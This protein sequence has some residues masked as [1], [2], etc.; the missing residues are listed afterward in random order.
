MSLSEFRARWLCNALWY[1]CLFWGSKQEGVS[2]TPTDTL[3]SPAFLDAFA[4][5]AAALQLFSG[6]IRVTVNDQ[7][8]S[9]AYGAEAIESE[10]SL[11]EDAIMP[12]ASNTKLFTAVAVHQLIEA[13]AIGWE[14]PISKYVRFWPADPPSLQCF[15]EAVRDGRNRCTCNCSH[16][17]RCPMKSPAPTS[18]QPCKCYSNP[19]NLQAA[20]YLCLNLNI[21]NVLVLVLE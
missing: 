15:D 1:V 3:S 8:Y 20:I 7:V 6:V 21:C 19:S 5:R 9:K 17:Q 11:Q 13:G 2:A 18:R 4:S 10:A 12:V 14:D 16:E